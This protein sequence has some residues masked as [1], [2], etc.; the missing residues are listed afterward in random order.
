[1]PYFPQNFSNF[2][3][4][5]VYDFPK[6]YAKSTSNPLKVSRLTQIYLFYIRWKFAKFLPEIFLAFLQ[7]LGIFSQNFPNFPQNF[8]KFYLK[9]PKKFILL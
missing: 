6:L 1:M 7:I 4:N 9:F 3:Q 8:D 5:F 2:P